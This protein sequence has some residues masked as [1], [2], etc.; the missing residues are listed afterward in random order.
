MKSSQPGLFRRAFSSGT[1]VSMKKLFAAS[2]LV[3]ALAAFATPAFALHHHRHHHHH[4]HA[5]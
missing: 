4:R 2:L 5:A 1:F 3:L